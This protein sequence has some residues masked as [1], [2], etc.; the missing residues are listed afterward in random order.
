MK[1][2][3]KISFGVLGVI[4]AL[5][6]LMFWYPLIAARVVAKASA[7]EENIEQLRTGLSAYLKDHKAYPVRLS[8]LYPKYVSDLSVFECAGSPKRI[9]RVEEIDSRSG[10]VLLLPG[11]TP[12]EYDDRP[13]LCD[14]RSNH[15]GEA[16][17]YYTAMNIS[18]GRWIG[19]L[20][21][22]GRIAFGLI[23]PSEV[24]N[25]LLRRLALLVES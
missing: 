16:T 11:I 8:A 7:C 23:F 2:S 3:T 22:N 10:Y 13:L 14:R 4:V 15:L 18:S 17:Y 20:L 1:L 21:V 19:A 24:A 9:E 12:S 5:L 6:V 25:R